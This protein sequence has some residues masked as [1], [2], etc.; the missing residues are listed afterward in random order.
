MLSFCGGNFLPKAILAL[1]FLLAMPA[2]PA[3]SST[4]NTATTVDAI[5]HRRQSASYSFTIEEAFTDFKARNLL[6]DDF[7]KPP[8]EANSGDLAL[9]GSSVKLDALEPLPTVFSLQAQ[10]HLDGVLQPELPPN[11]LFTNQED[12]ALWVVVPSNDDDAANNDGQ[13]LLHTAVRTDPVTG[14]MASLM[15]ITEELQLQVFAEVV[16]AVLFGC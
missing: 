12:P 10:Y 16:R 8:I 4:N 13:P 11:V 5:P 1:T 14:K 9:D 3:G 2:L 6:R 15:P 7:A